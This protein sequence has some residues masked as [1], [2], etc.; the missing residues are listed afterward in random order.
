MKDKILKA[1]DDHRQDIIDIGEYILSNPE[2]GY[3]EY[4]TADKIC[5]VLDSLG[6][7]YRRDIAITGV[8]CTIGNPDA[9]YN[10][11]VIGE[12][13]AVK[14]YHNPHADKQTGA[15]HAC[16]HNV[17]IANM[18]GVLYGLLESGMLEEIGGKVTFFAVP[19]EEFVELEY[20]QSLVDQGLISKFGGKQ[21]L[22]ARGEFDDIDM[23]IMVHSMTGEDGLAVSVGGSSLGFDT[24]Q[25]TF[26][27]KSAHGSTPFDGVN[28]LN[29]AMLA[30][31][32]VALNRE[33]FR[34]EDHIRI[35]PIITNGGD[36][37]N[38]VPAT[39]TIETY[40][41]GANT[42]AIQRAGEVV[43]RC[44]RGS[45][46][47]IGAE[48]EILH[49]EGYKPMSQNALMSEIFAS[50]AT[51]LRPDIKVYRGVDMI[52][53][54]DMGDLTEIMPAIQPCM[55]GYV[56]AL[57]GEDFAIADEESAYILPAKVIALTVYDLIKD[58][59]A[60]ADKCI[61]EFKNK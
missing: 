46:M 44:M 41:R 6:L 16:G 33:T 48:V 3:K 27:G 15:S 25:I 58:N 4:K 39:A 9:R 11:C 7:K 43:D 14:C 55:S 24:K 47:Q 52:G 29:S 50:N 17:Q 59:Y 18:I 8:K 49:T 2:L 20:R 10:I 19:A 37:V 54:T 57:H 40:V 31:M 22:I 61:T 12:L 1:I 34:D 32:G 35:H 5:Q 45:A 38:V 36:L 51:L 23:A 26:R 30:L 13:D 60:L 42:Q 56:G 28:A 21:E 53:S